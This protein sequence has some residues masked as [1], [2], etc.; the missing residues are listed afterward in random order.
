MLT[1]FQTSL[2]AVNRSEDESGIIKSADY[3]H[4]LIANEIA[5]G[6]PS[7]RIVIGGFSQGGAMSLL[8][9]LSSP[10]KL[11]GIFA[12]SS[13]LLLQGKAQQIITEKGSDANKETKIFQ[14]HGDMDQTVKYE[15]G[16]LTADKLKEWGYN[17]D[18]KTY[19]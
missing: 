10:D 3:F 8:S 17:V 6:I 16:K 4:G 7:E 1:Y 18:F 11:G 2:S 13:Y 15:F 5:S 14:A 19:K 12:L 9:G